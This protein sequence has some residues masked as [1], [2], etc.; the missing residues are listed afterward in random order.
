MVA[1][2]LEPRP[3]E[4]D[5]APPEAV[6]EFGS[7]PP[8]R[9]RWST[10]AMGRGWGRDLAADRRTVPLAAALAA[11]AILASL[12]SEWQITT[13]DR[14]VFVGGAGDRLI[15]TE[16]TDLGAL[17]GGYLVGVFL[18]AAMTVLTMFGPPAGR[19][20]A[21]LTGLSAGGTLLGVLLAIANSLGGQSRIVSRLYTLQVE[22]EQLQL[23]Y[24][25]GLWCAFVG[26]LLAGLA[27]YLAG[28]HLTPVPAAAESSAES[29]AATTDTWSWR[30]PSGPVE[31]RPVDEPLELTVG[32]ATPFT[33]LSDDRDM[34]GRRD[35]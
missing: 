10:S 12:I 35:Q 30:R 33:S 23:A 2:A 7:P 16:V 27:L 29:T 13:V 32:P 18:L 34:P 20:Y 24:G 14:A 1:M 5:T 8:A 26:V 15:P 25:R 21:R 3:I 6:V 22:G 11:V 17:G 9:R 31:E 4:P 28:R 19:Q